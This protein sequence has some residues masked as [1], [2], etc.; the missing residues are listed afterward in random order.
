MTA[1]TAAQLS[2]EQKRLA[3]RLHRLSEKQDR[4]W[5][6]LIT[7]ARSADMSWAQIGAALG[8]TR[9][10]AWERFTKSPHCGR[11]DDHPAHGTCPGPPVIEG[12]HQKAM[13]P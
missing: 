1:P 11:V 13:H 10:A 7:A 4:Q 5:R 2:P 6:D 12:G 3:R 9:Q 8:I